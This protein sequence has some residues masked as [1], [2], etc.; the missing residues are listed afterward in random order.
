MRGQGGVRGTGSGERD[1]E[2]E[3]R[4]E[5]GGEGVRGTGRRERDRE[6]DKHHQ[7]IARLR[8]ITLC[9]SPLYVKI[10]LAT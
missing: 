9:N 1:R 6:Q 3:G 5:Q 8:G 2:G 7:I 10:E 4:E